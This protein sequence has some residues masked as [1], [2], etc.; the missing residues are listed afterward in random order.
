MIPFIDLRRQHHALRAELLAAAGAEVMSRSGRSD[1]Y[2]APRDFSF[3]VRGKF[4]NGLSLQV[5]AEVLE[6]YPDGVWLVELAALADASL[7]PQAV[8][9][10][11]GV[12]EQPGRP[13]IE[14]L[15]EYLRAKSLL[16]VLDNCEHLLAATTQISELLAACSGLRVLA[17]SRERLRLRGEREYPVPPLAVPDSVAS[18][19][20]APSPDWLAG[21]AAVRLF[22]ARAA[23]VRPGFA[24]TAEN[25]GAVV[26][27]CRRLDGLPLAI[28][29][30]AAWVRVLPPAD[31]LARLEAR[32]PLLRGGGADQ[33]PRLRTM[34]DAIAWSHDRLSD[35][36][37]R[38]LVAQLARGVEMTPDLAMKLLRFNARLRF[39]AFGYVPQG[40]CVVFSHTLL[41]GETLDAVEIETALRDLS[42]LADEFDDRIVEEAGGQ[43]MQDLI[44]ASAASALFSEM[45]G[46]G[47][48]GD[49]DRQ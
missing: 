49:W 15:S 46:P 2:G 21:V 4:P 48:W 37:R 24:V 44:D 29:L 40:S 12:R 11:L 43:R 6:E 33:P 19:R 28:E 20:V 35:D 17:T 13:L 25:A 41:G 1:S 27:I 34:R 8:A 7:V 22:A 3:E 9:S 47:D 39:G 16:L 31:L 5:V 32:L 30:A 14:T 23:D 36:E 26:E 18:A 42:V 45:D 38:R 10:A